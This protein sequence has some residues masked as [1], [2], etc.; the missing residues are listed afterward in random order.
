MTDRQQRRADRDRLLASPPD[1]GV[2]AVRHLVTGREAVVVTENLDGL[3]NRIEFARQTGAFSALPDPRMAA[4]AR[5]H[6]MDGIEVRE[7]ERV[8][9]EPGTTRDELRSDLETLA[10]LWRERLAGS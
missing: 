1:A 4:D 2:V 9:V 3:R 8:T 5:D 6:G 7:L 10:A